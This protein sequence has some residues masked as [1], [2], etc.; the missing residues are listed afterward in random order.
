ME[1]RIYALQHR[2]T[3]H[4]PFYAA[5]AD[6]GAAVAIAAAFWRV[7]D[8]NQLPFYAADAN[9]GAAVAIAAAF[10]RVFDDG[11]RKY[12]RNYWVIAAKACKDRGWAKFH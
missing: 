11:D 6:N 3:N 5:A 1:A 12:H 10:W 8:D 7:F 4:F 2:A 9:N